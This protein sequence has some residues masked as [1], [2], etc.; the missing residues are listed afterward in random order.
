MGVMGIMVPILSVVGGLSLGFAGFYMRY[1][2]RMEMISR[3]IDISKLND[4]PRRR[5]SPLR[6]GL[7]VLGAGIGL[8]LA[9]V[10]CNT[11]VVDSH[12]GEDHLV[13]Y[14]GFVATFVGLGLILSHLLEK[15]EPEE[16]NK[17]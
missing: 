3:G 15:K 5:R 16:A 6:S 7:V 4:M 13:I 1:R 12:P 17:I 2:E 10:F 11:L 14:F 8:L 9:K